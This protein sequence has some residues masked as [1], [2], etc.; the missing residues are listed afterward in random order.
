MTLPTKAE[1]VAL[2]LMEKYRCEFC[3]QWNQSLAPV[4]GLG[5]CSLDQH[6]TRGDHY[7]CYLLPKRQETESGS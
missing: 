7:C 2:K 4:E 3:A 1:V 5:V 6:T